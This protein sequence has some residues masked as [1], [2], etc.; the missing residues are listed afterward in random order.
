MVTKIAAPEATTANSACLAA[1]FVTYGLYGPE[2]LFLAR[3]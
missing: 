3:R 2:A 1:I